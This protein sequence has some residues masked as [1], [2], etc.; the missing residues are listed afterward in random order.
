MIFK[1]KSFVNNIKKRI[2]SKKLCML[3]EN[4]V[5]ESSGTIENLS[6]NPSKISIGRN[7]VI[8]GKLLVFAHQGEIIIG[9]NCFIGERTE[10]WSSAKIKIGNNVQI[11]HNVNIM[12]TDSHPKDPKLRSEH[13][14]E[15]IKKG[16]P[17][18][19]NIV[20]NIN[21]KPVSI[22]DNVWIG[23][24]SSIK[25]G[26]DIGNNSIVSS[27][28]IVVKNIPKDTIYHNLVEPIFRK[29]IF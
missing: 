4:S 10:I 13:Y 7:C 1:L 11:S 3:G 16:H 20:D 18:S 14:L 5:I 9:D 29:L 17:S 6:E 27:N 25:K 19:G 21:S 22:N 26:V 12:D 2:L 23:H 28:S 8:K 15:I 24:S